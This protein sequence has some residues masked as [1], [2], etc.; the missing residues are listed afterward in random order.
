MNP[1]MC[2]AKWANEDVHLLPERAVWWPAQRVLLVADLHLGKA[3]TYRALGQPVPAGTT[4]ENLARLTVLIVKYV[5]QKIVFLGDFLHAAAAR[6]ESLLIAVHEWRIQ[7]RA[8]DMLLVRGNH[9]SRAGDPPSSLQISVVDEAFLLG[10]FAL[11]HH[12][13]LHAT[14]FVMAGHV[15]PVCQL[16]GRGRDRLRLPCFAVQDGQAILP[17]FGEFTGGWEVQ[18]QAPRLIY[19]LGD[20]GVWRVPPR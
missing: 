13:Q 2:I 1:T 11:C 15:H 14:H 5:P 18:N 20:G 7:H 3:A 19:A 17:A 4:Q 12:P 8:I 16:A 10:P 6:T 9:D